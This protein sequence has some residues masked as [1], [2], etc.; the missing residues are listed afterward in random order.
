[1]NEQSLRQHLC[2]IGRLCYQ[3]GYLVGY[4]GNLSIRMADGT[5]LITPSGLHKGSLQPEQLII[6]NLDGQRVDEPN[7]TNRHFHSSSETPMHIEAYKQRPDINAI[8]HT[9]APYAVTMS[10]GRQSIPHDLIPETFFLLGRIPVTPY[11]MPSST[12]D[13]DAVRDVIRDHDTLVLERH[14]TL[15]VGDNLMQ[16]FMRTETVES[17]AKIAYKLVALGGSTPIP[18]HEMQKLQ[19]LRRDAGLAKPNEKL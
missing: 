17:A 16:A 7:E 1:M 18:T 15:A 6:I 3:K 12:E 19:Q 9:H 8:I 10:I 2:E 14:G 13:A 4:A 5:I 11:A